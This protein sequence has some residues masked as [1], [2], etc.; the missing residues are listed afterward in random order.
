MI[1]NEDNKKE[2]DPDL[3]SQY[4]EYRKLAKKRMN[5]LPGARRDKY[6]DVTTLAIRKGNK[7][8]EKLAKERESELDF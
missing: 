4:R 5:E 1:L 8:W 6:D 3:E 7:V 2:W